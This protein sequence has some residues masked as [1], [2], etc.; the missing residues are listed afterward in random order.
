MTDI[1]SLYR[2]YKRYAF[3]IAYRMLGSVTDAE[4]AV[5]DCFAELNKKDLGG[6]GNIKAY[7]AK[8]MTNR[9]LNI[10][11]SAR[12]QREVYKGEWLPEPLTPNYDLPEETAERND[13]LSYAFLVMLELLSPVERAVFLLR[14]VFEYDYG[15][16]ADAV[17]KSEANCRQ[18]YSRAKRSLQSGES[19]RPSGTQAK[20]GR[21][22][23]VEKFVSAFEH[24]DIEKMLEILS[25]DAIL[26]TDGGGFTR[27]AINPI[28]S[29]KRVLAM[30]T[31]PRVFKLLRECETSIADIN[32]EANLVF[33]L[34]G[35]VKAVLCFKQTAQG[36]RFGNL[37][38]I[39]NPEKIGHVGI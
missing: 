32:G 18:I 28:V 14:E 21:I 26:I 33:S 15:L 6:I 5:Q 11:N 20:E 13:T 19:A 34:Q 35:V 31:S 4:D 36:D 3:S 9:C 2:T 25:E 8:G 1:D 38:M 30:V 23:L 24:Y 29:R 39:L 7:L 17:G 27:S 22:A 37:Y 10:L 16:I 12:K